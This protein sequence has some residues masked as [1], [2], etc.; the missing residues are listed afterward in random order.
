[1]IVAIH[2]IRCYPYFAAGGTAPLAAEAL[3]T[4]WAAALGVPFT[5]TDVAAAYYSQLLHLGTAQ[6]GDDPERLPAGGQRLFVDWVAALGAPAEV[7][8]GPGTLPVRQAGA[9]LAARFGPAAKAFAVVFCREVHTYVADPDS[10]RRAAVR[11][12]VRRVLAERRPRVVI[13]HSLGSVVAYEALWHRPVDL[14]LLIT[15]GS[16]LGMPQVIF[17]RLS[18]GEGNEGAKG[19]RPPGVRRWVNLADIGDIVAV[20]RDLPGLFPGIDAHHEVSLGLVASHKATRYLARPE[21]G[22]EL[23]AVL[24]AD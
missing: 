12:E 23:A 14:D 13:A 24:G 2:G 17:E 15:L 19:A 20:P 11:E 10:P 21:V 5:S 4:E 18:L 7:T 6:G 9:W 22:R 1:M 3:A 8:M 16:P